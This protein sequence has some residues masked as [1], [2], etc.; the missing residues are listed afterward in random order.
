MVAASGPAVIPVGVL[1]PAHR[2]VADLP[3]DAL[4]ALEGSF[5]PLGISPDLLLG[6]RVDAVAHSWQAH[7]G[8]PMWGCSGLG[9]LARLESDPGHLAQWAQVLMRLPAPTVAALRQAGNRWAALSATVL[10]N[11]DTAAASWAPTTAGDSALPI[12]RQP[13]FALLR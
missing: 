7:C 10:K 12:D 8:P 11:L 3:P 13:A 1:W 6:K 9:L 2:A 5:G 4:A